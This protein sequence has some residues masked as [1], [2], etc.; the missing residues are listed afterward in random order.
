MPLRKL[1]FFTML[2]TIVVGFIARRSLE[3]A[4][5]GF[6]TPTYN[7][8]P[9]DPV[10]APAR[11]KP[12]DRG[13]I[14]LPVQSKNTD[15]LHA[16][17]LL[18]A[19]RGLADPNF[20]KTVILLVQYDSEGVVGLILNRRTD[21]PLSHV[22]EGLKA[23]RGRSDQVYLGGPVGTPAL[24]AL[25]ESTAKLDGAERIFGSVYLISTKPLFEHI[26]STRPDPSVFHVYLGYAGWSPAQLRME[27][28]VGAWF[29]F[30]ADAKTV[31]DADPDSMWLEMIQ[32][33]ELKFARV[34]PIEG[35]IASVFEVPF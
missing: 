22:L 3:V 20:A 19:S 10:V 7:S 18:V 12:E 26:L 32:K 31:F 1:C 14:F 34:E 15:D 17:S 30:Q 11:S 23:A 21:I 25:L 27:V 28:E 4:L 6:H 33:T 8:W 2:A 35:P 5:K 29:I 9:H 16:G 13:T 24:F